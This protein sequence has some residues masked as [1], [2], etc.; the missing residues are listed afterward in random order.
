MSEEGTGFKDNYFTEL[1]S[2]SEEGSYRAS[3]LDRH[4]TARRKPPPATSRRVGLER[5]AHD[6]GG[7]ASGNEDRAAVQRRVA[8]EER[9][10]DGHLLPGLRNMSRGS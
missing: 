2:G 1:R 3:E 5:R 10:R 7:R 9:V 6:L 8:F 4:R